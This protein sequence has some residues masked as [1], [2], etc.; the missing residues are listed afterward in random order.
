MLV[1]END[2]KQEYTKITGNHSSIKSPKR[3]KLA[4]G[5]EPLE[6]V[7]QILNSK[8]NEKMDTIQP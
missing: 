8:L 1:A 4:N 7:T 5:K 6:D 3:K 2:E